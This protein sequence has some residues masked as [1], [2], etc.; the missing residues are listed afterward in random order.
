MAEIAQRM[1]SVTRARRCCTGC[2]KV[3]RYGFDCAKYRKMM[4]FAGETEIQPC[5]GLCGHRPV[6]TRWLRVGP[7]S[8]GRESDRQTDCP[9]AGSGIKQLSREQ[10]ESKIVP[11][12]PNTRDGG[13]K[14]PSNSLNLRHSYEG[15]VPGGGIAARLNFNNLRPSGTLFYY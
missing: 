12:F 13:T 1:G 10:S 6:A 15:M 2:A 3:E 14:L 7:R 5:S 4:L 8:D 11:L 9:F